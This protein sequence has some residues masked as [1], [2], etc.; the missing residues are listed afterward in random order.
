ML[1]LDLR[2]VVIGIDPEDSSALRRT[3]AKILSGE[4][5]WFA[6]NVDRVIAE[7]AESLGLEARFSWLD[8][9]FTL[10][11][12]DETKRLF[13]N[14]QEMGWESEALTP[15]QY[16]FVRAFICWLSSVLFTRLEGKRPS[17]LLVDTGEETGFSFFWKLSQRQSILLEYLRQMM[18][19]NA[20]L[21]KRVRANLLEMSLAAGK[22]VNFQDG[23]IVNTTTTYARFSGSS[24]SADHLPR[25][26]GILCLGFYC[27]LVDQ[28]EVAMAV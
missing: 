16:L 12:G 11:E 15:K 23:N 22:R 20:E 19:S 26:I 1:S 3:Q 27:W 13:L 14:P 17:L 24:I 2:Q 28:A 6:Q 5:E 8:L 18:N 10:I 9:E 7:Y 4:D 21:T 25:K